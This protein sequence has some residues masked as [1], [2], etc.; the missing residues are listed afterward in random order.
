V[1]MREI[2]IDKVT[3][4]I[5][6]GTGGEALENAEKLLSELTG[7]KPVRTLAK[8]RNPV[9]KL[10]PGMEIGVKATLRKGKA[11]EF[12]KKAFASKKNTIPASAFDNMGNF[13][14]GVKEYIDF[15]G[16]KYNPKIG[17][18]GFDVCVTLR[19]RG[20]R[21]SRRKIAKSKIGKKHRIT[22]EEAMEFVK[23]K[24]GVTI[25]GG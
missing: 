17:M 3:V 21:V 12:L 13:S 25:E 18:F 4:N 2:L 14:I 24:F 1:D 6:V 7:V 15:P 23:N 11:E 10:R 5:G 16:A 22:K 9:F 20:Y 19:R 8:K